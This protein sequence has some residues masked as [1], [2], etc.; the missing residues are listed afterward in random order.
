MARTLD[1]IIGNADA[2]ARIFEDAEPEDL[3]P[4]S[5]VDKLRLAAMR[6]GLI[7]KEIVG[8]IHDAREESASWEQIGEAVGTS[9]EAARKRYSHYV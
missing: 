6:R 4:V 1:Q 2:Y 9:G 8:I 7:E 5:A 3:R